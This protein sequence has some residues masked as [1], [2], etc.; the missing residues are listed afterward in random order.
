MSRTRPHPP[1]AAARDAGGSGTQRRR[2]PPARPPPPRPFPHPRPRPPCCRYWWMWPSLL[3]L[4]LPAR[5]PRFTC[6]LG[7]WWWCCGD[8]NQGKGANS[9]FF[10]SFV[11]AAHFFFCHHFC[12]RRLVF[13]QHGLAFL[14]FYLLVFSRFVC[15]IFLHA[16]SLFCETYDLLTNASRQSFLSR[17]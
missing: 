13:Q 10:P 11:S 5:W 12:H 15:A 8:M 1:R 4:P 3:L 9:S 17:C 6:R 14:V 16:T 7:W 2:P